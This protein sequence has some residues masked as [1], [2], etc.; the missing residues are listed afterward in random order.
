M[1]NLFENLKK[2]NFWASNKPNL[3][4]IRNDYLENIKKYINNKLVKVLIGQRRVGK[5]YIMRQIIHFLIE[6]KNVNPHNIFYLNKEFIDFDEIVDYKQLN[7][8]FLYYKKTLKVEGKVFILIDEIQ[9]IK[10][11]ELFVNSYSQDYT[12]Q[13]EIFI[14]GSNS[15]LL[16][17]ELA[18]HLSGRYVEFMILPYSF[19]EFTIL[20]RQKK[21][22]DSYLEYIKFGGL[23]E[24]F[25]LNSQETKRNYVENVRNTIILR[26][27][28]ARY[29]VK[30]IELLE[31]LFKYIMSNIGNLTSV[32]NIVAYYKSIG[33]KTNYETVSSYLRFITDTM[34]VHELERYDIKGK[35]TL[36]G[37]R[38]YFLNDLSFRNL[39]F[40]FRPYDISNILENAV[41]LQIMQAGFQVNIG[42]MSNREID[43]VA[44][45]ADK[46]IYVQVT[47]LLTDQK[48]M[49]REFGN[50]QKIDD[51]YPKIVISLDDIKFADI[52]GIKHYRAWEVDFNSFLV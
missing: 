45:K 40:G 28:V 7:Q 31:S 24:L 43:F 32:A 12:N 50:L 38:K 17:K 35:Q 11:W 36:G 51:N 22:K 6:N 33:K 49:D 44:Q 48:V 9:N 26:D 1:E 8:L 13:Y 21:T 30:D 42:T 2:Y 15:N 52:E 41:L 3:G 4:F 39:I 16:S 18:S 46:K 23:P 5:S 34:I 29:F 20:K 25:H 10:G 27:I 19:E 37:Q 14:S 47:Y